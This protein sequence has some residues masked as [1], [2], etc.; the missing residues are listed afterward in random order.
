LY[1]IGPTLIFL[2]TGR[3]PAEFLELQPDGYR[4]NLASIPAITPP[5]QS[6]IDKVTQRRVRDRYQTARDLAQALKEALAVRL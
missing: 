4:F 6:L 1:A 3:N 2:L 5:V